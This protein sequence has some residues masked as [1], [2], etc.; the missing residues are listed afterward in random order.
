M[1]SGL[2]VVVSDLL[3]EVRGAFL[4]VGLFHPET[5]NGTDH[6]DDATSP[7]G[8]HGIVTLEALGVEETGNCRSKSTA[9]TGGG[10]GHT[11]DGT[12]HFVG[13]GSVG[14]ENGG[15]G[16]GHD[17][18]GDLADQCNVGCGHLNLCGEKDEVRHDQIERRPDA[19]DEAEGS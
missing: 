10:G 2:R 17:M 16:E 3:L 18:E 13:G 9:Q 7:P 1:E 15:C 12:E 11:V 8:E 4:G 6:T 19:E 14:E 5:L